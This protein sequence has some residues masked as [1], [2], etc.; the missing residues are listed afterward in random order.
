MSAHTPG[1]WFVPKSFGT[2]YVEAR[3]DGGMLQEVAAC[4]PTQEPT[5]QYAN[6]R[7][8]AAAPELLE[9]LNNLLEAV[10]SMQG[11]YGCVRGDTPEDS[12]TF[13]HEEWAEKF[14]QERAN[15]AVAVLAKATGSAA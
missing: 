12:D 6:A 14:L 13:M 2:Q 8:I 5:Q 11:T 10:E 15:D 7:L 4:G 1:P 3:I 9:A